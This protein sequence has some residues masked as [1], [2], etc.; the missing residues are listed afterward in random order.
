MKEI[1]YVIAIFVVFIVYLFGRTKEE[2]EKD[3]EIYDGKYF[4]TDDILTDPTYMS[5]PGNIFHNK[6]HHDDP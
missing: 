6:L 1:L 5:I 3:K 2:K 4:D